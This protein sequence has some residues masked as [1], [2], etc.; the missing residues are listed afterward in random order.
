MTQKKGKKKDKDILIDFFFSMHSTEL[1][2]LEYLSG[3]VLK[4][5]IINNV[6]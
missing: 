2:L 5:S 3:F 4:W 1:F 6:L